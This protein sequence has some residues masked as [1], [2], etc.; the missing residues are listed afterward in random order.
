MEILQI[1]AAF[2]SAAICRNHPAIRFQLALFWSTN[3]PRYARSLA[4]LTVA[5]HAGFALRA[6]LHVPA[7]EPSRW[8]N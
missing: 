2:L 3:F 1:Y 8:Q 4:D 7:A 5:K 6:R